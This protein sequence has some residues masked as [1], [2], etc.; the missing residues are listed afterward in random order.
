MSN[1]NR[2]EQATSAELPY[3]DSLSAFAANS[4]EST[5]A[6]VNAVLALVSDQ[7]GLRTS[8]LTHIT[9][10]ENR[11]HVVAAYNQPDG[12]DVDAGIDLPL[13]DTF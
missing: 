8:F 9:S 6:L 11:N 10:G 2:V 7:L 1:L 13:E 12:C 3:L 5:D 4:F